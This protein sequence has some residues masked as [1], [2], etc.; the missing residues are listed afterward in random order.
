MSNSMKGL[1]S[2]LVA[3]L[4]VS[5]LVL[6]KTSLNF[7]PEF[8]LIRLL[9]R[10]G[11]ITPV[12]AWMDH[13]I[14]GVVIWGLIFAAYDSTAG[15]GNYIVRGLVLGVVAWLVMMV[16]FMPIVGGGLFGHKL[17]IW[18]AVVPLIYHI[19]YGAALGLTYGALSTWVPAKAQSPEVTPQKT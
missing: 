3:T 11:S 12:Q 13:F 18:A 17:G 10:L 9:A 1:V 4:V 5:G 2:G 7:A 14:I 8:G 16:A 6:L 15:K 19:V